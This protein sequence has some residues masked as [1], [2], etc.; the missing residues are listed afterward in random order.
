MVQIVANWAELEG[1]VESAGTGT[2]RLRVRV[3][4]AE[5]VEGFP[6]LLAGAVGSV[7][8]L[9]TGGQPQPF[10]LHPGDRVRCRVRRAALDRY[11]VLPGSVSQ[12]SAD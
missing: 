6:N 11:F 10:A 3:L 9:E 7:I 4:G 12:A 8:D 5:P 2:G 1:V